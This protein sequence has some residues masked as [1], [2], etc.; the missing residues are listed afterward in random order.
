MYIDFTEDIKELQDID[1]SW[2]GVYA[3]RKPEFPDT[4][5]FWIDTDSM[6]TYMYDGIQWVQ[7]LLSEV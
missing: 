6:V 3:G 5:S 2:S 7:V 4:G 1:R